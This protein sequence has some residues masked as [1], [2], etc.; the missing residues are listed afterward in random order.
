M[1][2]LTE[3]NKCTGCS[4]CHDICKKSAIEMLEDDTG[5]LYPQVNEKLC[6]NCGL[7]EKNCPINCETIFNSSKEAY[8][9]RYRENNA[10]SSSGGMFRAIAS[11]F[12]N[13][14][15]D[16]VGAVF[17]HNRV[18]HELL[19][20][21]DRYLEACGSKYL[22]S[23][24]RFTY[25]KIENALNN[26]KK[27]L[28]TGCPCQCDAVKRYFEKNRN[29]GKLFTCEIM[30][31]GVPSPGVFRKYIDYLENKERSKVISYNFRSKVYGWRRPSIEICYL[32]GKE[33]IYTHAE[34]PF[35]NWF[36]RHLSLRVSCFNCKYR[37][38]ERVA[39]ITIGDFWGLIDLEISVDYEDNGVSAILIN[40][41]KGKDILESIKNICEL[42]PISC[43][44][45][46]FHNR[47]SVENF[48]IPQERR[49][50][51]NDYKTV[52]I[53]KLIRLYPPENIIVS[54]F[55]KIKRYLER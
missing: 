6:V 38:T 19:K 3:Q 47:P 36:G 8:Y 41:Q 32:N 54:W 29:A 1:P 26:G 34:S 55:R 4:L 42:T 11:I 23:D 46:F 50:F 18:Y 24:M 33:K 15:D 13:N 37:N 49:A 25:R 12:A 5:F 7:C 9:G 22:Q 28:F 35:H 48:P 31:H 45:A 43:T 20:G 21:N 27:V 10:K 16:V 52:S 2:Q 51:F 14:K 17:D 40:T 44:Q 39:D 30:C 53:E